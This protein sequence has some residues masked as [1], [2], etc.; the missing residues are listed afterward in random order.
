[1]TTEQA[2]GQAVSLLDTLGF[3]PYLT[4]I[5]VVTVAIFAYNY[6]TGNR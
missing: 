5:A 6:L 1:M 4:A 3:L 2:L